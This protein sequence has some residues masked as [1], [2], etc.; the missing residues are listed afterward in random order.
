MCELLG[1]SSNKPATT[2]LS[3]T[4]L[5]AHSAPPTSIKD[6]WGVGYYEGNDVR[7]IKGVEPANES[8]WVRFIERQ[9]IRS[10]IVMSHIRKATMGDFAFFKGSR[11]PR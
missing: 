9:D 7:L 6:A 11:L 3:L 4:K 5:A 10:A 2:R 8:D 1:M